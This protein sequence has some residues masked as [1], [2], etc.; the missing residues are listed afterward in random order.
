MAAA[1]RPQ[2]VYELLRNDHA[3]RR[4]PREGVV[5]ASASVRPADGPGQALRAPAMT[6]NSSTDS[7]SALRAG[8]MSSC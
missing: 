4:V 1:D 3:T 7:V 5:N 8:S 6:T 2:R